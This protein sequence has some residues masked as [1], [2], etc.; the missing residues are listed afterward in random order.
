M[1]K[2]KVMIIDDD[3]D[4]IETMRGFLDNY[5][6][7][8]IIATANN[9]TDAVEL[10]KTLDIDIVLLDVNFKGKNEGMCIASDIH[11]LKNQT[12]I[13]MLTCMDQEE[14]ILNSFLMGVSN[15]IY[16]TNYRQVP[17]IIR[18]MY[19][20]VSPIEILARKYFNQ[21]KEKQLEVLTR[22]EKEIF[23]LIESGYTQSQIA[24]LQFKTKGTLR[25]QV[26]KIIKKLGV[27]NSKEAV[28]IFRLENT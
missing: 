3:L 11:R 2:I 27:R 9:R 6:E 24:R 1:H 16:K 8:S 10:V 15:Y 7:I 12:K 23:K 28:N 19:N 4:W 25:S 20:N 22:T 14:I 13:I 5:D 18:D 26:N 17:Y 21:Q